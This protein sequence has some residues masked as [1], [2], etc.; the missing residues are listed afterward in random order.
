MPVYEILEMYREIQRNGSYDYK[1]FL[2]DG[3]NVVIKKVA[4]SMRSLVRRGGFYR[5]DWIAIEKEEDGIEFRAA[6][7]GECSYASVHGREFDSWQYLTIRTGTELKRTEQQE[8]GD[9]SQ[10]EALGFDPAELHHRVFLP[11]L[12]DILPYSTSP[13]PEESARPMGVHGE[14]YKSDT[15]EYYTV[16]EWCRSNCPKKPIIGRVAYKTRM[17]STTYDRRYPFYFFIILTSREHLLKVIVWGEDVSYSSLNV[18]D[19][20]GIPKFTKKR[21]LTGVTTIESN[22]FTEAAYFR[23]PEISAKKMV[24]I[25]LKK[26]GT[27]PEPIFEEVHGEIEYLSVINRMYS[28]LLYEYYLLRIGDA[29][30]LF[31]YDSSREFYRLETGL[32][33]RIT[34]LRASERGRSKFYIST[35]YSHVET[36]DPC[37]DEKSRIRIFLSGLG[38]GASGPKRFKGSKEERRSRI[39]GAIGFVPDK[40]DSV[41]GMYEKRPV[42]ING[43]EYLLGAFMAPSRI[44]LGDLG[45]EVEKLVLNETKKFLAWGTLKAVDFSNF[46]PQEPVG[47]GDGTVVIYTRD[48][49]Q[50]QQVPAYIIVEDGEEELVYLFN[51]HWTQED[52][53]EALYELL[54]C[55]TFE[56]VKGSIGRRMLFVINAFRAS[57]DTVLNYLS[58]TSLPVE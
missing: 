48:G 15:E 38:D 46:L 22:T 36:L 12:N 2:F 45:A 47:V 57:E 7:P 18:G 4:P 11:L 49:R 16:D 14:R 29:K 50:V 33:V 9:A 5:E 26:S 10:G 24:R 1:M 6:E 55:S 44:R 54:G 53:T 21:S 13:L 20:V 34:N 30:I 31:F 40:F 41:D 35:I 28:N 32:S 17:S 19:V 8:H 58:H 42:V 51:N 37:G 25:R 56:E 23:C 52:G 43:T 27:M 39:F 3:R